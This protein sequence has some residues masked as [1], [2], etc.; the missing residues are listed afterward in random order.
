MIPTYT[1]PPVYNTLVKEYN[2]F[3]YVAITA[4]YHSGR[5]NTY[6]ECNCSSF[7][8]EE[9]VKSFINEIAG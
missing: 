1:P 2:G 3:A 6:Y 9:E 7:N 4:E 8:T 5:T